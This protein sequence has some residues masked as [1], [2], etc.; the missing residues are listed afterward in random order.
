MKNA[1]FLQRED[2]AFFPPEEPSE[3]FTSLIPAQVLRRLERMRPE[4]IGMEQLARAISKNR[5]PVGAATTVAPLF[6]GTLRFART[7]FSS[8][9]TNFAVPDHDLNIAMQYA[10]LVIGPISQ[11][12]S[13]YGSNKLQ[14]ARTTIPFN[15][16]VTNGK[17]NDGKLSAWVEQLAKANGLGADSCLIFLN[18]QGVINTDADPAQGVGGYHNISSSGVPYAFVNVM[19]QG[20][21]V[22][23]KQDVYA[24]A[25]SHEIA[26]MCLVGDTKIPLLDGTEVAVKDL[27]GK[28]HFWVYSCKNN[29]ELRP[30]RGHSA[31]L[32]RPNT[33]V[34]KVTLDNGAAITCTPDHK[35]LMRNAQYKEARELKPNDSLMPLYRRREILDERKKRKGM[36]AYEQVYNPAKDDWVWTHRMVVPYC[37]QGYVRHHVNFNRFDNSP[38]N[39]RVIRWEDHQRLH[40]KHIKLYAVKGKKHEFTPEGMLKQRENGRRN[41]TEYNKSAKHASDIKNYWTVERR[42][43]FGER[44][45]PYAIQNGK[46]SIDRLRSPEMREKARRSITTYN[47]SEAH[48]KIA[49]NLG[50]KMFIGFHKD[51]SMVQKLKTAATNNIKRYNASPA[52]QQQRAFNLH[53]RW[54]VRREIAN[55]NCQFCSVKALGT[56]RNHKVL[57]IEP[58]GKAD[59]YDIVVDNYHDFAVG[60]GVFVHN[61]V[62]PEA[63]GSNAEVSDSC[64]G[65]CSVDYR[66]YFDSKGNWLGGSATR[67]YAFFIDGIATPATVAQCPA[68]VSSCSYPPPKTPSL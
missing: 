31:R 59:V 27:V 50:R 62:D 23:D 52:S 1:K 54:H 28:D 41:I 56:S 46:N 5:P 47:K 68:P 20:L 38:D 35:F 18:P 48:R 33:D 13:Q 34:V 26:E 61:C 25:L 12:A 44:M 43:S 60:A 37:S 30:G 57:A 39:L 55:P 24:V 36:Y 11:Y 63:N 65:N 51:P 4:E 29:G 22:D 45:R 9:E 66:N 7:T 19:G 8:G 3:G 21:T 32:T 58:V 53:S 17:Y 6:S 49:V 42:R 16:P 40:S 14:L 67:A 15:A 2:V 64:A 10:G